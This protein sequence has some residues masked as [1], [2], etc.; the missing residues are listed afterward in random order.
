MKYYS[1]NYYEPDTQD[2]HTIKGFR[3]GY[4]Y[5]SE[6]SA[7]NIWFYKKIDF[8]PDLDFVLNSKA[9]ATDLLESVEISSDYLCVSPKFYEILQAHNLPEH[10]HFDAKV[11]W[12]KDILIYHFLNFSFRLTWDDNDIIDLGKTKFFSKR[13]EPFLQALPPTAEEGI[14]GEFQ[15]ESWSEF[16][17]IR[18]KKENNDTHKIILPLNTLYVK[19]KNF[20]ELDLFPLT[21]KN[22]GKSSFRFVVSEKLAK[23]IID[24]KISGVEVEPLP[25]EIVLS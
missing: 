17:S 11:R 13:N 20:L 19:N 18:K 21:F 2:F 14:M 25:F 15:V 24:N 7:T 4:D 5:E 1:L 22:I 8:I 23:A 10:Q 16:H 3:K 6:N 12:K 9:Q